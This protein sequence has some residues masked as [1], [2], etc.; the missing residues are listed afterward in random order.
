LFF[1]NCCFFL[2]SLLS[3]CTP[4]QACLTSIDSLGDPT[5]SAHHCRTMCAVPI[6]IRPGASLNRESLL[7]SNITNIINWSSS[8]KCNK[9]D[10]IEY[11]CIRNIVNRHDM[12]TDANL[13]VL[14]EAV[15]YVESIRISGGA[16]LSHCWYGKNRRCVICYPR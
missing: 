10:D 15:E 1:V 12:V 3:S 5:T 2:H 9:Y 16:V 7:R 4:K 8:S 6:H 11:M 14:D 13:D